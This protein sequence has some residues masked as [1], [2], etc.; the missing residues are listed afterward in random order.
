ME[1][2]TPHLAAV[3]HS[4]GWR[5]VE[6]ELMIWAANELRKLRTGVDQPEILAAQTRLNAW[7]QVLRLVRQ[8]Q[9]LQIIGNR[10]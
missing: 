8:D 7:E 2:A 6:E 1:E 3:A 4:Q 9:S 5:Y 10:E